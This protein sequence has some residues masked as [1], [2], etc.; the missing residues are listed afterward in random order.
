MGFEPTRTCALPPFQDGAFDHS[1]I[2]PKHLNLAGS[3][4]FEPSEPFGPFRFERSALNLSA[5]YPL[6]SLAETVRFE[7]TAGSHLRRFSR[8]LP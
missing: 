3:E 4:G 7:L 2:A 5:S 6:P 1:A 8:P